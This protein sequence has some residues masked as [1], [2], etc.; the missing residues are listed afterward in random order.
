MKQEALDCLSLSL[1]YYTLRDCVKEQRP[2]LMNDSKL[3]LIDSQI[4]QLEQFFED[5]IR[6]LAYNGDYSL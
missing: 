1:K 2:I 3:S 6:E 5:R 4:E